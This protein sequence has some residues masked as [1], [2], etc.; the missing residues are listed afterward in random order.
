MDEREYSLVRRKP[1]GYNNFWGK[2]RRHVSGLSLGQRKIQRC[3]EQKKT[4]NPDFIW[5]IS[6]L[7]TGAIL[8][9][10]GALLDYFQSDSKNNAVAVA[11]QIDPEVN[12]E[13]PSREILRILQATPSELLV[14]ICQEAQLNYNT[15]VSGSA[16]RKRQRIIRVVID[17]SLNQCWN[18][19]MKTAS[20][21]D[22]CLKSWQQGILH[23]YL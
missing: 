21:A 16:T 9:S 4:P 22:R 2:C 19:S 17:F 8:E 18:M 7:F 12:A 10:G 13:S 20:S 15:L 11:R 23:E 14:S 5:S 1:S 3:T 6:D